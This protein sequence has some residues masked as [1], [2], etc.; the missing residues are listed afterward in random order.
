MDANLIPIPNFYVELIPSEDTR[1]SMGTDN[2]FRYKWIYKIDSLGLGILHIRS[3]IY[4]EPKE[5][6][7]EY[8]VECMPNPRLR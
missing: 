4:I 6:N 2:S 3:S 8:E 5:S 7:L 1:G